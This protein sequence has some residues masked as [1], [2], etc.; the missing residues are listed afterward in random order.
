MSLNTSGFKLPQAQYME[1]ADITEAF[2]RFCQRLQPI[3][4]H[5]ENPDYA[6]RNFQTQRIRSDSN[7]WARCGA[8]SDGTHSFGY[9]ADKITNNSTGW[10]LGLFTHEAVHLQIGTTY[11]KAGHPSEF[12]DLYQQ[13]ANSVLRSFQDYANLFKSDVDEDE[14]REFLIHDPNASIVDRRSMTVF[15]AQKQM[16]DVA[17]LDLSDHYDPFGKSWLYVKRTAVDLVVDEVDKARKER[18][19]WEFTPMPQEEIMKWTRKHNDVLQSGE[20][21]DWYCKPPRAVEVKRNNSTRYRVDPT[22]ADN[23]KHDH[24]RA[25]IAYHLVENGDYKT[26]NL[27]TG[28]SL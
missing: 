5:D 15:E 10:L 8:R 20:S 26:I 13:Y 17:G 21:H 16:A 24:V 23:P 14:Y 11:R 1:D 19:A 18:M 22:L 28:S 27:L 2:A 4:L 25:S 12:Y 3:H 6:R 9:N 7:T